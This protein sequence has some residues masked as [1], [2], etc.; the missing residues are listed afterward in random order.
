MSAVPVNP[1]LSKTI[2]LALLLSCSVGCPS[3][4]LMRLENQLLHLQNQELLSSLDECKENQAPN[5]FVSTV[6][7]EVILADLKQAGIHGAQISETGLV[8]VPVHGENAS[9]TLTIQHFEEEKVL[10]LAAT[11]YL[12]LEQAESSPAMVLLLTQLAALNFELL[13]GKFQMDPR[14]GSISLSVE[15][16]LEDGLGIRTFS[17]V[18]QHLIS[19]ADDQYPELLRVAQGGTL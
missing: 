7:P 2:S 12:T 16:N 8:T 6:T 3:T 15:I 14:S 18:V 13:L 9:F 17:A 5:G 19:T 4:K 11:D 1:S 10:F